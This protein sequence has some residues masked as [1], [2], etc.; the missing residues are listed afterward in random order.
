MKTMI[1]K[2]NKTNIST[3]KLIKENTKLQKLCDNRKDII[4]LNAHQLRTSLTATKWTVSMFMGGDF[5]KVTDE[6]KITLQK[7]FENNDQA[8]RLVNE[9]LLVNKSNKPAMQYV[10]EKDN[11]VEL[12]DKVVYEFEAEA[13][14][15][16]IKIIF[17]NH[18]KKVSPVLIDKDRIRIVLQNIIENAIKYNKEGGKVFIFVKEEKKMMQISVRDTGMGIKNREKIFQ[19][20]FRDENAIKLTDG[21]GIGLYH[22][23]KIVE[24]HKGKMWFENNE[25]IGSTFYFTVP[26]TRS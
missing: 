13:Y 14:S 5:G 19:K 9:M 12:I 22:S 1:I 20:Y 8:I 6:Q 24:A 18:G 3:D 25:D 7:V 26:L 11:I 17:E 15:K 21:S 2:N 23:K 4:S 16:N 10:F